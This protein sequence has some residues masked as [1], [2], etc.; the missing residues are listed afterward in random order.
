MEELGKVSQFRVHPPY[1]HLGLCAEQNSDRDTAEH[2]GSKALR[3]KVTR[4]QTLE[5]PPSP[6]LTLSPMMLL[7]RALE[8]RL[9]FGLENKEASIA[10][11]CAA[12]EG[13]IWQDSHQRWAPEGHVTPV[14]VIPPLALFPEPSSSFAGFVPS[15][16]CP[17][18][19]SAVKYIV[20]IRV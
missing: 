7:S 14:F 3:W 9:S 4:A 15:L 19:C 11:L 8:D 2:L 16:C 18:L 20:C 13:L 12:G 17:H 10:P 1:R 6:A 5:V